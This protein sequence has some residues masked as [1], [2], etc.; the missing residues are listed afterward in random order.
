MWVGIEQLSEYLVL[1]KAIDSSYLMEVIS[2]LWF[3][4]SELTRMRFWVS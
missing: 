1:V 3:G 2:S 4:L